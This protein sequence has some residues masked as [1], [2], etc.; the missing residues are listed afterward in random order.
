MSKIEGENPKPEIHFLLPMF[1]ITV[2]VNGHLQN[3]QLSQQ[4]Y[5]DIVECEEGEIDPLNY[6]QIWSWF[7]EHVHEFL[8]DVVSEIGPV[9]TDNVKL[10]ALQLTVIAGP[11]GVGE[12]LDCKD[13]MDS[14]NTAFKRA[15]SGGDEED[16][17]D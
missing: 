5:V 4:A 16:D 7:N 13:C 15:V 8:M 14:Y 9:D 1:D 2:S 12:V 10:V 11:E 17:D 3:Y 6:V